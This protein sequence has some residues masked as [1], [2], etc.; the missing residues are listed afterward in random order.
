MILKKAK[1]HSWRLVFWFTA[2]LLFIFAVTPRG[3][4]Q[5]LE[6]SVSSTASVV[7]ESDAPPAF[8]YTKKFIISSYYSPLPDQ[9]YYF[10][11]NYEADVKLN[12][13]GV[14]AAD[15]TEVFPGMAAASKAYPFGSKMEVPGFGIVSIHD[16]GGA[17]K[18]NRLDLWMGRGE[19]GLARALGWG[20]RT[21]E[22][23]VY[24]PDANLSESVNFESVPMM[25]LS[26]F[27][28]Q[29]TYFQQ[30][31]GEG[32]EGPLVSELQR[33]LKKLGFFQGEISGYFGNETKNA[34]EKFQR[35]RKVITEERDPAA[36]NFGPRSRMAL[37]AFL[38]ERKAEELAKLPIGTFASGDRG[39]A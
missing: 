33:F 27:L 15:G 7:E 24:G 29:T 11:G 8:P 19:E 18:G 20:M 5:T 2:G 38:N 17:I 14:H 37:E 22:V 23:T 30:D 25:D 31:L 28:V 4:A 26:R 16:R 39:D 13:E 34:V 21:L 9:K 3:Y 36:G 10:R 6:S 32:D 12:G 35:S 1:F